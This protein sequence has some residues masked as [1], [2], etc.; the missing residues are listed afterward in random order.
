M[1]HLTKV[2]LIVAIGSLNAFAIWNTC[3][4]LTGN[5]GKNK[6]QTEMEIKNFEA[7]LNSE[8]FFLTVK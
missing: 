5:F 6:Q 1:K 3:V 2:V 4:E 8:E 7:K